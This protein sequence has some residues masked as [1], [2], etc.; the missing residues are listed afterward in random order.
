[1]QERWPP[2]LDWPAESRIFILILEIQISFPCLSGLDC[3]Q[4]SL[5]KASKSMSKQK[6]KSKAD[7]FTYETF[8]STLASKFNDLS[9][10]LQQIAQFVLDHPIDTALDTAAEIAA[11]LGVQPSSL[12]RF[13][14]TVGIDG[15]SQVQKIFRTHLVQ[16]LPNYSDNYSIRFEV[17]K[18]EQSEEKFA[19]LD[20]FANANRKALD[21]LTQEIR[22][23]QLD[24]AFDLI[25]GAECVYLLGLRRSFPAAAYLYYM[26]RQMDIRADLLLDGVGGLLHE[27]RRA[28]GKDDVLIAFTFPSYA[29]EVISITREV[30]ERGAKIIVITDRLASQVVSMSDIHFFVDKYTVGGFRTVSG[31]LCLA[32]V[33]AIGLGMSGGQVDQKDLRSDRREQS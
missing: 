31:T 27:Q 6:K 15:F 26:M 14:Q 29:D 2:N 3:L 5:T 11:K 16:Q 22:P 9:K 1:M 7:D 21:S 19:V 18:R 25:S 20:V 30:S 23:E 28:I 24:K 8:C 10:Q 32:Q 4:Y 13:A 33:L 17:L 12:I